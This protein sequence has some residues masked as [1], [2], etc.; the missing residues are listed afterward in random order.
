MACLKRHKGASRGKCA[1]G[2][3][4]YGLGLVAF[5]KASMLVI[6]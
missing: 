1:Q 2:G 3:V 4:W 5:N 6:R